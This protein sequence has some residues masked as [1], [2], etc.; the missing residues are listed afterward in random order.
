MWDPVIGV[1]NVAIGVFLHV[2]ISG[3]L[4]RTDERRAYW[5]TWREQ[6]P[7]FTRWG[8]AFLVAFGALRIGLGVFD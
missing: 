5:S 7:L 1:I 6:H 2:L 8:P 3:K 4:S